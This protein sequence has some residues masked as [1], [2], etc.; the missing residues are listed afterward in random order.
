MEGTPFGRYRLVELMGRGGMGEVWRAYD[1]DM[2]RVVALKV[3]PKTYARDKVFR[4]RFRREAQA[5]AG[6]D[7]P[8]VVP[9]HEFGEVDGRLYVTMR[10][11]KGRDVDTL[12]EDGPLEPARAVSIIEQVAMALDAAH[13]IGL[14]HRDVKPSNILVA[15]ND[16]AYLIDFG[17]SRAAQHTRLTG[18]G[19]QIG[20][21]A[22]MAPERFT[23][24]PVDARADVYALACVLYQSLT[25]K[26]PFPNQSIAQITAAH[27]LSP[28]PKPS[29]SQ[30]TV[31]EQM[32]DVISTG[33]AKEPSRRYQSTRDLA[34]A[35][36]AALPT[37][38]GTEATVRRRTIRPRAG[39]LALQYAARSDRGLERAENEDSVYAG[40]RLLAV[41]DGMGSRVAS[42]LVIAALSHLDDEKPGGDMRNKLERAIRDG[43]TAIADHVQAHPELRG[44]GTALTAIYFDGGER[45]ALAHIG[46]S[47]AYLLR[48]G[49]LNQITRDQIITGPQFDQSRL[50]PAARARMMRRLTGHELPTLKTLQ[51]RP[52]DRFL[53]CTHGLFDP[54]DEEASPRRWKYPMSLNVATV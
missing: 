23:S 40:P 51:A 32:D 46:A 11:I 10:L 15:E 33:M 43:N 27:M 2:D 20:T 28:A 18:T 7:E 37:P 21:L 35:A 45:I 9:I 50:T 48:D 29:E 26:Q 8:H 44:T 38:D 34:K 12:L 3:L 1:P 36:R 25:N 4:E 42:Q 39:A 5:A 49:E 54:V 22:Y 41:A 47:R 52:G 31:P 14:V 6:L 30:P 17:I 24:G 53:L 19:V 13:R 16:F